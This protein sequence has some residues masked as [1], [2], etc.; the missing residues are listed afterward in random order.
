[1][2]DEILMKTANMMARLT[3]TIMRSQAERVYPGSRL[4]KSIE[5][6]PQIQPKTVSFGIDMVSYGKYQNIGTYGR[7]ANK[8]G[9]FN[10]KPQ[11]RGNKRTWSPSGITPAF[12]TSL[13]PAQKL[14][15]YKIYKDMLTKYTKDSLIKSFKIK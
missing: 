11:R 12:F 15:I 4:A 3:Q 14:R 1:M 2:A 13:N 10:A 9:P 8:L 6:K 5:V 7:R